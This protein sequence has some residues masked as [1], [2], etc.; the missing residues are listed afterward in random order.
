MTRSDRILGAVCLALGAAFI[1][2]ASGIETGFIVDPLGP[3]TF[4]III[5]CLLVIASAF[6][7]LRPDPEPEWPARG[8]AWEIVGAVVVLVGYALALEPVGFV[9][10]TAIAAALLSW[11]LGS[12]PLW[13]AV[14]G[15]GI[16]V[17]IYAVFHLALGL[18]LA[19]GPLGF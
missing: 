10:A 18:S 17:G 13:A 11:R 2:S 8:R 12:A 6:V 19:K 15:V 14:S 16:S 4:P 5:G 9:V 7:L 3:K 1:W